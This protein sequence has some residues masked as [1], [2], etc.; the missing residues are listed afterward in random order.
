VEGGLAHNTII[1]YQADLADFYVYASACGRA[2]PP[3]I[4]AEDISG[5]IAY[6]CERKLSARSRA[7]HLAAVRQFFRFCVA[8]K[9]CEINPAANLEP[10]RLERNLPHEL[11]PTAVTKLLAAIEGNEVLALRNR[12]MLELFY[13]CGARVSEICDLKLQWLDLKNRTAR[14]VGKGAKHRMMVFGEP[15]AAALTQYL[16][17]ARGQLDPTRKQPFVFL[18][19]RG[20]RLCRENVCAI[21]RDLARQAGLSQRVYPHLLRHSFATH[22]LAGGANLR[23]VQ[24]MLGHSDVATT[25]IYTHVHHQAKFAAFQQFHPRA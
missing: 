25:E 23:A 2:A 5:Y 18:S 16:T 22:L 17:I 20:R 7:R 11:S 4:T 13:A 6:M 1:A 15:A 3:E 21:V 12:A 14:F 10:A 24:E 19:C 9:I 8:E